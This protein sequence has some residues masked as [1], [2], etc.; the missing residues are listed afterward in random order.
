MKKN[1]LVIDDHPLYRAGLNSILVRLAS[2]VCIDE[3]SSVMG[4]LSSL[5]GDKW[6]DLIIFDWHLPDGGGVQGLLGIY[7]LARNA[8]I[9]VV[10]GDEEEAVRITALQ[11]GATAYLSKSTL[12]WV[13]GETMANILEAGAITASLHR[14]APPLP[15]DGSRLRSGI[16]LTRRQQEVLVQLAKGYPNKRI[17]TALGLAE[18]TVRAHVSDILQALNVKNRTEAVVAAGERGAINQFVGAKGRFWPT[19][20]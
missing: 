5:G 19:A 20:F 6:Y 4:A 9:V 14:K 10:S 11:I 3:A 17:A 18:T 1:I 8:P 16:V 15:A 12:P 7:Q 13:M 2:E